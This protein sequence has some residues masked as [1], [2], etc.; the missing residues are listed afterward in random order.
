M[1]YF[2]SRRRPQ[3]ATFGLRSFL[4]FNF[5]TTSFGFAV[6]NPSLVFVFC[7]IWFA[8]RLIIQITQDLC[9]RK[10]WADFSTMKLPAHL[11]QP[12]AVAALTF[13]AILCLISVGESLKVIASSP[14]ATAHN[15]EWSL[16]AKRAWKPEQNTSSSD[17][18]Q[19]RADN[20]EANGSGKDVF[21][22]PSAVNLT[23]DGYVDVAD[24][25]EL[26]VLPLPG[27]I[28]TGVSIVGCLFGGCSSTASPLGIAPG[29]PTPHPIGPT[30]LPSPASAPT[31]PPGAGLFPSVL[32]IL[33]GAPTT[34]PLGS[35]A[36]NAPLGG[37]LSVLSQAAPSPKPVGSTITAPPAVPTGS[38]NLLSGVGVL[39]G[40]ASALN[41]VLGSTE[42]SNGGGPGLLGQ[43]SANIL[44]PIA[45]IASNP[46]SIL[47]NPG[48][49]ISNLQSQVSAVLGSMPSAVAAGIQLASNVGGDL[50][51]A[52]NAS[53]DLLD[54]AP[55]VA[56]GVAGQVG[57]LLDAAPA[58]ATGIP[59][60]ALHA[61]DQVGSVLSAVPGFGQNAN[62]I[63]AS[64]RNDLSAAVAVAALQVSALAGVVNSQVVGVLP[65]TLQPLVSGVLSSLATSALSTPPGTPSTSSPN[66]VSMLSS[67]S[68]SI[69]S[70]S[71]AAAATNA[72]VNSAA[73]SALSGLSS[74]VSQISRL[75]LTVPMTTSTS[76]S[77]AIGKFFPWLPIVKESSPDTS[78]LRQQS[79]RI[80]RGHNDYHLLC[81]DHNCLGNF[82]IVTD[83]Y[84]D[85]MSIRLRSIHT[86]ANLSSSIHVGIWDILSWFWRVF[87]SVPEQASNWI[88]HRALSW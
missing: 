87:I 80:I 61:V 51:D 64:L 4:D 49:A 75:S 13:L 47:A 28:A 11:S 46:A 68:S 70:A 79:R 38:G 82:Y 73:N 39:G 66:L 53:T 9:C 58:L 17:P 62:G 72:A 7:H 3:R 83:Q 31:G 50:A 8:R 48:G 44:N 77:S 35:P 16:A 32:S 60:A 24:E 84:C 42:T 85:K 40:V 14:L 45:S 34:T 81:S 10:P 69:T 20:A 27:P 37:L 78:F 18:A 41:G 74:L 30:L 71:P 54:A 76:P 67:L 33:A 43:L 36:N 29:M 65:A 52:L 2:D 22:V 26:P 19:S 1:L 56:G 15:K 25:A 6:P 59:A 12:L 57:S 23:D 63:L 55:N 86:H 88:Q 5:G 21:K